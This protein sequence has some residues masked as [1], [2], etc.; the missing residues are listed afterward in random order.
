MKKLANILTIAIT[1]AAM[2][3]TSSPIPA[4]AATSNPGSAAQT[5]AQAAA[6]AAQAQTTQPTN[7]ETENTTTNQPDTAT[8][9]PAEPE[10]TT[11]PQPAQNPTTPSLQSTLSGQQANTA[12]PTAATDGTVPTA[13][14]H[15]ATASQNGVT[16]TVAWN[17]APAGTATT[18][19]VA[20]SGGSTAAK[21]RM[22]VPTYWDTD[23]SQESVCDPTLGQWSGAS[24]YKAI[25]TDG[26]DFTF[27]LTASGRYNVLFYFMDSENGIGYLRTTVVATVDDPARPSV[28]QIV[29]NVVAQ[30]RQQTEGS[31]YAM[32]P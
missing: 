28:T 5:E 27:E 17:V 26:Y 14:A 31:E 21:A 10:P 8:P 4:I 24:S 15:T 13:Y 20:Q 9:A 25:G 19:R 11:D 32:A 3:V 1:T 18:F 6:D 16:F 29:N 22:D 2:L 23:G 12:Q 30:C 7:G